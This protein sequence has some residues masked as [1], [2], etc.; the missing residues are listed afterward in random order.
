MTNFNN[1]N[2][3]LQFGPTLAN[4]FS[5]AE[6]P[7]M[8]IVHNPSNNAVQ[9]DLD[10]NTFAKLNPVCPDPDVGYQPLSD[11]LVE[12][13]LD[14]TMLYF[15]NFCTARQIKLDE[16]YWRRNIRRILKTKT[17]D[18]ALVI[19]SP[20]G[21]GKSTWMQSFLQAI[22]DLMKEQPEF[23]LSL[24]GVV[25]VLQ[26]VE[27]LNELA[28]L[29]NGDCASEHPTMVSL[30]GW[31]DSGSRRGLCRNPSVDNYDA[32]LRQQC[33]YAEKCPILHFP[34]EAK[35]A[36]IVGMTQ[37]RFC[38]LRDQG[39][40][41]VLYRQCP[42]GQEHPR[43][44]ILFDEKFQMAS[45][46]AVNADTINAAS[47]AF[48]ALIQKLDLTDQ[49]VCGL[50]QWLDR[51]VRRLF[52][53]LRYDLRRDTDEGPE[54]ILV[55]VLTLTE[56]MRKEYGDYTQFRNFMVQRGKRYLNRPLADIL[57]VLDHLLQGGKCLFTKTEGFTIHYI[58]PPQILFGN[59]LTII[60]DATAQVDE[61]YQSVQHLS[62]FLNDEPTRTDRKVVFI[63][64]NHEAFNVSKSAM[65]STW[66]L[67]LLVQTISQII[68]FTSK[69]DKVFVCTYKDYSVVLAKELQTV[70]LP[71]DYK[72]I[73]LMADRKEDT[74]PYF[75]GVN[76][77]NA[78]NEATHV[79][80]VGYP[81]L[82][83][84]TYLAC[85][86]A[87]YGM[88]AIETE[89]ETC[90][91]QKDKVT[92][93][94]LWQL[95]SVQKYMAHHLAARME[96]DIYRC[97]QRRP[98]FKGEIH[99]HLF[100]PP[101]GAYQLLKKRLPGVTQLDENDVPANLN[102]LKRRSRSYQGGTTSYGRLESF[103]SEWDGEEISVN[104]LREQLGISAAVWKDLMKDDDIKSL[105]KKHG[106]VPVGRG[107]NRKW[108]QARDLCA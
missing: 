81:R 37:E 88:S 45:V 91:S 80:L 61:D 24:V 13:L 39:L 84:S 87:A 34:E 106:V 43:R 73:L 65:Y 70:M 95:P 78:F 31:T 26:K 63:R 10:I 68:S 58:Q 12:K 105:M 20:A 35:I 36:P 49:R 55:G 46:T 22:R 11:Y 44:Y 25:V 5:V 102:Q 3:E 85:A 99:V 72:K 14:R 75:N 60:F 82:P 79:I 59:S 8:G 33:P 16:K 38:Q 86:C 94:D 4:N 27:D 90:L 67:P 77:S 7:S 104:Q 54:D 6:D 32:C 30:Q 100:H 52:Q 19:S 21:S 89:L 76:G 53:Q 23:D 40:D 83:L 47:N 51:T 74:L 71:E 62:T 48:S 18:K 15:K 17:P 108:T 1:K 50:Q 66:K 97:A 56:D 2:N 28:D 9:H 96:Q 42:D 92:Q 98:D 69:N 107:V 57:L 101:V 64:H 103:L 93:N 41:S 29:L